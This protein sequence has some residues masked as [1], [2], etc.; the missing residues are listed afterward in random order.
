MKR[1]SFTG[2]IG[3]AIACPLAARVQPSMPIIGYLSLTS[4][5]ERPT[6]LTGSLKGLESDASNQVRVDLNLKT[7]EA[8]DLDVP[9]S[10]L[11]RTDEV[12]E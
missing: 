5:E 7:A 3:G 8:L 10:I 4:S 9:T 1:R 12:I 6:L 11:L 2:V